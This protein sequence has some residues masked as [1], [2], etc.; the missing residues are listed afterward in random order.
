MRLEPTKETIMFKALSNLR[1]FSI[2]FIAMLLSLTA[3][4]AKLE[5]SETDK[6]IKDLKASGS[7]ETGKPVHNLPLDSIKL[8]QGFSIDVYAIGVENAR[9]MALGEKGTVFGLR[10]S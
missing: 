3:C 8:P 9:Q 4:E 2:I 10:F 7:V 5:G 1:I 6:Q